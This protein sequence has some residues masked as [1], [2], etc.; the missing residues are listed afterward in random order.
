MPD[1]SI[2]DDYANKTVVNEA[3]LELQALTRFSVFLDRIIVLLSDVIGK[4]EQDFLDL[5]ENIMRFTSRMGDF[6]TSR[7]GLRR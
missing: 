1:V 6:Q 3:S 2:T 5:G 7:Q 4:R